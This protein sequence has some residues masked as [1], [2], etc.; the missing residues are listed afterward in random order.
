[1]DF[2]ALL[3]AAIM[4]MDDAAY[5]ALVKLAG[6]I[7]DPD[8]KELVLGVLPLVKVYADKKAAKL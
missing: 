1:M 7:P 2:K 3:P 4:L 8:L 5:P 6:M